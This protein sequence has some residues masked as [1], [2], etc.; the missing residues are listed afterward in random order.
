MARRFGNKKRFAR[1][2]AR[3]GGRTR[4]FASGGKGQTLTIRVLSE[5]AGG[6]VSSVQDA[7]GPKAVAPTKARF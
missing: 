1:K 7:F 3:K 4:R 6:N 5:N 2:P